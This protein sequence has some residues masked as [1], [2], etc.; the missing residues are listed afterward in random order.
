MT[1]PPA[2]Q[3]PDEPAAELAPGWYPDPDDPAKQA[4]WNGRSWRRPIATSS[5]ASA[6]TAGAKSGRPGW[7]LPVLAGIVA[8]VV[9]AGIAVFA[10]NRGSGS[11][12]GAAAGGGS[13]DSS[14]GAQATGP[15]VGTNGVTVVLPDG[16]EEVPSEDAAFTAWADA[17]AT[18]SPDVVAAIKKDRA[19]PGQKISVIAV[20]KSDDHTYKTYAL[21]TANAPVGT[22]ATTYATTVENTL[23]ATLHDV[24]VTTGTLG[25]HPAVLATYD[26]VSA[27]VPPQ[28]GQ[29]YVLDSSASA[30]VTVTAW[31]AT[32]AP[33]VA[34]QI[35]ATVSFG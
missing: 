17:A 19:V 3:P 9:V 32:K 30:V 27:L 35:G 7:L 25:G 5:T 15:R 18:N 33:D 1:E 16:W 28:G 21:V 34:K 6:E 23:S 22:D 13:G 31:D 2:P 8:L 20:P 12:T 11:S 10:M 26:Y 29:A 4:Y 14:A 24:S